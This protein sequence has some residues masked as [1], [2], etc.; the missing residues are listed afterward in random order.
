MFDDFDLQITP[1]E[2]ESVVLYYY[3][4]IYESPVTNEMQNTVLSS[5]GQEIR[6]AA[7]KWQVRILLGSP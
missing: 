3:D 1:E 5:K 7:V 2:N 6:R 4:E